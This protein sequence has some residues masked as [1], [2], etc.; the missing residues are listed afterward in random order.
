MVDTLETAANCGVSLSPRRQD[1]PALKLV[2]PT[3]AAEPVGFDE[4]IAN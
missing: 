3:I 4:L 2:P 1:E